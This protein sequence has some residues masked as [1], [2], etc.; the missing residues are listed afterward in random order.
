MRQIDLIVRR[1][2]VIALIGAALA[3][4][5]Q[6]V[7]APGPLDV[8]VTGG[9]SV[10]LFNPVASFFF[11]R[12]ANSAGP[13]NLTFAFGPPGAGW[14]PIAGDWDNNSV[15]TVGLYSITTSTFFL[16]NTN[17]AGAANI[18]FGYGPASAGWIPI[19]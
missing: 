18:T 8:I 5:G 11:L 14:I 3:G 15:E 4:S 6:V 1:V 17:N 2:L 7:A 12:N 13:A 10:G 9:A 19:A 16:R